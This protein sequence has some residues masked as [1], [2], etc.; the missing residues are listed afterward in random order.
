MFDTRPRLDP[1]ALAAWL[2]GLLYISPAVAFYIVCRYSL[3]DLP[4]ELA[5]RVWRAVEG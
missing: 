5:D 2:L 4:P 1:A 3:A